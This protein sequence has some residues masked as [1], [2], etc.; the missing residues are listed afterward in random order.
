MCIFTLSQCPLGNNPIRNHDNTFVVQASLSG[1]QLVF[2]S[3]SLPSHAPHFALRHDVDAVVWLPPPVSITPP[4]EPSW[5]HVDSFNALGY[6]QASKENRKFT[7]SPGN[8]KFVV[9]SDCDRH[10]FVYVQPSGGFKVN[11]AAEF[12]HTLS[13]KTDILGLAASSGGLVFILTSNSLIALKV[14]I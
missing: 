12:V 10:V 8:L 4:H 13:E 3:Q 1:R 9:V 2:I 5:M 14:P 11:S 7:I 6:V